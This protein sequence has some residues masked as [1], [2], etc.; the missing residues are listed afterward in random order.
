MNWLQERMQRNRAQPPAGR[1]GGPKPAAPPNM[2]PRRT[3]L[4]FLIVILIIRPQ[5]ILGSRA[6]IG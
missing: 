3:W 6:R 1:P 4:T 5:G 2:P